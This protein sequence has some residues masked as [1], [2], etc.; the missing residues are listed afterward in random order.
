MM[1]IA[2]AVMQKGVKQCVI[3]A[4][5]THSLMGAHGMY[6]NCDDRLLDKSKSEQYYA[7]VDD[8]RVCIHCRV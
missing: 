7:R 8:L 6:D 2:F 5:R 4:L 1:E 3:N